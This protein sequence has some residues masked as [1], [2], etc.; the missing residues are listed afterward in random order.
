[1]P[2]LEIKGPGISTLRKMR[3]AKQGMI[4]LSL[5]RRSGT[6]LRTAGWGAAIFVNQTMGKHKR[7]EKMHIGLIGGIGPAAT[8]F[9][10]RKLAKA[11]SAANRVMD[12]SIVNADTPTLLNNLNKDARLEQAQIFLGFVERLQAAGADFAV[13]TSLAGHFCIDELERISPLPILNAIPVLDKFFAKQGLSRIGLL[14]TQTVL[15]SRLYGGVQSVDIVAPTGADL[16]RT[17]DHYVDMATAGSATDVHRKFFT[18]LG[19]RLCSE[20]GADAIALAGTDLFLVFDGSEFG[21]PVIDCAQVH[22]DA[23][24]SKSMG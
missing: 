4:W 3:C 23:I 9:Y 24:I 17:H 16:E 10:Y 20:Q 18:T 21:F 12:L 6:N 2:G 1:M 15:Q 19:Q 11:Y 14:G 8:E 7:D 22:I 13:V 5:L